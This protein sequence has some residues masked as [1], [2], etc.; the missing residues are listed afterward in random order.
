MYGLV[1]RGPIFR[2]PNHD[3]VPVGAFG[4]VKRF[5]T[6]FEQVFQGIPFVVKAL[7]DSN[8]MCKIID[9]DNDRNYY[10]IINTLGGH[11]GNRSHKCEHPQSCFSG[12]VSRGEI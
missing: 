5:I 6:P 3:T 7:G 1:I 9:I 2:I 12:L 8:L 4:F 11:N 10:S